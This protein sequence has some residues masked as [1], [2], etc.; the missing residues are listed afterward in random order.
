MSFTTH[1]YRFLCPCG[2]E[3]CFKDKKS[4]DMSVKLHTKKCVEAQ[5]ADKCTNNSH[6]YPKKE[7]KYQG[8][9]SVGAKAQ[10]N[11]DDSNYGFK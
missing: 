7:I 4:R 3:A 10:Q 1:L 5:Q 9:T 11:F 2:K 6:Y 8:Q